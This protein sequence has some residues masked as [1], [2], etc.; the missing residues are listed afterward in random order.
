MQNLNLNLNS[1]VRLNIVIF[2]GA[3]M[4]VESGLSTFRDTDG[5]WHNFDWKRCASAAGFYENPQ[6]VLDFYNQRRNQLATVFPNDAHKTLAALEDFHNVTIIT[7][8]V[9]NLHERAGSRNVIH[10]H[11]ELTKIT[12]SIERLN[13]NNIEEMNLTQNI[14]VGMKAKDG[15]QMRPYIVWFGECVDSQLLKQ[16]KV[17]IRNAD[18]FVVIGT[19]L[20]VSPAAGLI[21]YAYHSIPKFIINPQNMEDSVPED[22]IH[23]QD[24]AVNGMQRLI[25]QIKALTD[26]YN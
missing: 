13:P 4:S 18:I 19:S 16:A 3:G 7:Q 5:I 10:L 26:I 17:A 2:T 15:S 9:D 1:P 14:T 24:T 21:K 11:G 25:H 22:F 20:K 23:I 8:N 12:S 6:L